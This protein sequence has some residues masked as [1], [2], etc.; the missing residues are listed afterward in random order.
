MAQNNKSIKE[1]LFFK[2]LRRLSMMPKKHI[3]GYKMLIST[4]LL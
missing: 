1:D 4:W 2:K 3:I